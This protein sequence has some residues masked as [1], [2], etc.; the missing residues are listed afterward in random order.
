[1]CK[2]Q[3]TSFTVN[4][5]LYDSIRWVNGST[6]ATQIADGSINPFKVKVY[7]DGCMAED[8]VNVNAPK[9]NLDVSNDFICFSKPIT[10]NNTSSVTFG[11]IANYNWNFGDGQ[12]IN[13]I[14]SPQ[15]TYTSFGPKAIQ[16]IVTGSPG[17]CMDTLRKIIAMDD[18][19]SFGITPVPA[20]ICYG[21]TVQYSN[22]STGGFNT[23]YTWTLNNANGQTGNTATYTHV[24]VGGNS[25]K[26]EAVNRCGMDSVRYAFTVLPLPKVNLGEDSIIM[27]PGE[28]RMIGINQAADSIFWSTG[29]RDKDSIS[30]DGLTSP[31]RVQVY[32][33]GCLATDSVLVS[34]NCDVFIPTAFSPNNDGYND[35]F[36]MMRN[37]VKSYTLKVYN[38]WGELV[39]Q[40][41]DI[42]NSWDG[43]YKG[44]PCPVDSY[45]Y[46]ATGVRFNNEPFSLKG[47]VTLLR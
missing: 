27:C 34:T 20:E 6:A 13:G 21:K 1:L 33:K 39:F 12:T 45:T 7:I 40:T 41:N 5:A 47:T 36:N 37:S 28:V 4:T 16:L 43:T 18:S 29:E 14:K 3:S 35:L 31:I 15:H 25:I 8:T 42:A 9:F 26:L 10:F 23:T 22:L 2:N 38:R 24:I 19:I 44:I 17:G 11:N 46:I 32:N 30:I